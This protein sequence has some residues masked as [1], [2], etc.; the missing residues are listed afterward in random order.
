MDLECTHYKKVQPTVE[1]A[2]LS[3]I[4]QFSNVT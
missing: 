3:V 4:Y 1:D 2:L